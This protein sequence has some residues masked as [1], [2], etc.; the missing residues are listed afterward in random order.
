MFFSS[1]KLPEDICK[2]TVC[3]NYAKCEPED[4]KPVCKCPLACSLSY[5]PVCGSDGKT[6]ANECLMRSS[7]C[8][9]KKMVTVAHAGKC[10]ELNCC[11][12]TP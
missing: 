10:G 6:Y 5:K 8:T 2:S 7:S 1:V 9:F 11:S 3:Q 12:L 4:G